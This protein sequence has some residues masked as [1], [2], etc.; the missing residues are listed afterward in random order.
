MNQDLVVPENYI[1]SPDD[2]P[3][4]AYHSI[5]INENITPQIYLEF[6][7]KDFESGQGDQS[8]VNAFANAKRAIH[9]QTDIISKAFGIGYLSKNHRDNFPKKIS[10]CENCGIVGSRILSKFN[11]IRNKIE[12]EYYLP[13]KDEVENII[14]V[15]E[16]F[17]AAT[18]RFISMF[19]TGIEFELE[20]QK[21]INIPS[22]AGIEFPVN[23]G[24]IYLF[25][26][27]KEVD[28]SKINPDNLVQWQRE[29]SVHFKAIQGEQYY[30]WVN[31][32]VSHTP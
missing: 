3:S 16:L 28:K 11:K 4:G 25:P 2:R 13:Q 24:V 5:A 1:I 20:P 18:A 19:P 26:D 8:N 22:I 17:L 32:L 12:H 6:A 7:I 10:F 29:N 14:D 30:K 27:I 15:V 23:E 31:F 21:E 9:F